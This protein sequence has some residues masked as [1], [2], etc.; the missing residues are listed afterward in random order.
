MKNKQCHC[1]ERI[2]PGKV[3]P[4]CGGVR[5]LKL[6]REVREVLEELTRET[7]DLGLYED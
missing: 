3:C 4:K 2:E 7:E 6:R 1:P 5:D